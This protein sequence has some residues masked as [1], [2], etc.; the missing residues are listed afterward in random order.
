MN[1]RNIAAFFMSCLLIITGKLKG[2][3]KRSANGE[4]I[5]SV[6]FHDPSKKLF[7]STIKWFLKRGFH[8]ITI[9]DLELIA[10]GQKDFPKSAVIITA[11][12]GW[13]NNKE[14]IARVANKYQIPVTIFASA[15]PISNGGAYW[16][17]YIAQANRQGLTNHSVTALK[18]VKNEDRLKIVEAVKQTLPLNREALTIEE[19]QGISNTPFVSIGSHTVTHPILTSCSDET[20]RYEISESKKILEGW[21]HKDI[22]HFAYP[23]GSYTDREI[24]FLKQ[25]GYKVAFTTNPQYITE[26]NL[27]DLYTLPRFDVLED[28]SFT[29]NICRMTGAWFNR[30]LFNAKN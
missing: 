16:W 2:I 20:S 27:S 4:I 11:D 21:L 13:K 10:R 9:T 5:L 7:E 24:G 12:D 14:N 6:Y 28:V 30:S 25:S 22:S 19:L 29:E 3:R 15:E 8:F 17:S 18:K 23:N 26:N 1:V